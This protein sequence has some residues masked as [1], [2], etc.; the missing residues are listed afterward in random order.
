MHWK[1][2]PTKFILSVLNAQPAHEFLF[3][4]FTVKLV[5]NLEQFEVNLEQSTQKIY[6]H[7]T[8]CGS[9]KVPGDQFP[10]NLS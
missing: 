3:Y 4:I 8:R 6:L 7:T 5:Q 10:D 2:N 1:K 9:H